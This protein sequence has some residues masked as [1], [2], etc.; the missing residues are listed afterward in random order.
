VFE[1]GGLAMEMRGADF[2]DKRL[3]ERLVGLV[4]RLAKAPEK[5]FPAQLDEAELEAAYRF[6]SNEAVHPESILQPHVSATMRRLS[7]EKVGLVLHDTTM[8]EFDPDGARIGLGRSHKKGQV[9]FAHTSLAVSADGERR[10][11]GALALSGF[12]RTDEPAENERVRWLTQMQQVEEQAEKCNCSALLIHVADREADHFPLLATMTLES[13]HFVIRMKHDRRLLEEDAGNPSWIT[14]ALALEAK[15]KVRR[16]VMLSGRVAAG[17]N[18]ITVRTHPSRGARGA[19]LCVGSTTVFVKRPT[20]QDRTLPPVLPINVVRVWEEHP[21]AGEAPVEW[22]LLTTEP[23]GTDDDMLRVVDW[24]RARWV[25]EEYFKA[26]K[27]G[28]SFEKRQIVTYSGLLN[29][30][31][32]FLPI[33]YQLLLLRTVSHTDANVPASVVLTRTQLK[34]LSAASSKP[35]PKNPTARDALLAIAR[36]GGHLKRNGDP[37]WLV[38]GRGYQDLIILTLGWRLAQREKM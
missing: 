6:F 27:T 3:S 18:P 30:L 2:G 25:I 10:P 13:R 20:H 8:M 24:Y 31:A 19:E 29:V 38:I 21:P 14:A 22:I 12:V 35:L 1:S 32:V 23:V 34:V 37:G 36:L 5:S 16:T 7:E 26:L 17:R 28:C 9:F 33:A 15:V 4:E 11:L